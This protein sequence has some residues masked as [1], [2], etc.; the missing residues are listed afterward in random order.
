MRNGHRDRTLAAVS[1]TAVVRAPRLPACVRTADPAAGA[2]RVRVWALVP[3][4]AAL[5]V[6]E[7]APHVVRIAYDAALS[8]I[9]AEQ[10]RA[11]RAGD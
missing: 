6:L 8:E 4:H 5:E 2:P 3:T 9:T 7:R 11:D 1:S 10:K